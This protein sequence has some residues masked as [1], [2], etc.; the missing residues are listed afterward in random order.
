MA[1]PVL[2]YDS[3]LDTTKKDGRMGRRVTLE[4]IARQS[5]VSLATVSL[6]LRDKP[7]INTKTRRRVLDTARE[8]GYRRKPVSEAPL[9]DGLQQVGVIIRSRAGDLPQTNQFYAP[10]LV[11]IEA[12][13][14]KQQINL[15]YATVPVDQDN[16]P[17]ELPRML[18]G[19]GL[20]GLLL[21]GAFVDATIERLMQRDAIST[22]LVDAYAA[23]NDYDSVISDNFR[24][25][26]QAVAYLIDRGH[27]HIGVVG[28]LP[29]AYPSIGER[30]RGYL[31]A[32]QDHNIAERYFADSHL[33]REEAAEAVTRL[34]RRSPKVT[35]LFCCNDETAIAVLQA[36]PALERRVPEN[37]SIIGFDDIDLAAHV[38]PA[39][40]TMQVDKISMGRMAVQLLANRVEYPAASHVTAVLRSTLIE[41]Q[42]VCTIRAE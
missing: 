33:T 36:A 35:A 16:H 18:Q 23:E 24:G 17:V 4:D 26:Y 30:R 7:G 29:N 3:Y 40:S 12:A 8:L 2:Y 34:L 9:S 42:S 1:K 22:V 38:T 13:C 10:V 41:R 21:V 15:L 32:L 11:G 20:D 19:N 14:R 27:R 28:S 31:Q 25:A 37:L 5:G 39:L 6:V